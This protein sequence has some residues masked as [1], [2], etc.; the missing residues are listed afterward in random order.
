MLSME[1][2]ND[3]FMMTT[4]HCL[5]VHDRL[6]THNYICDFSMLG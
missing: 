4:R 3:F 1:N 5:G 6:L 2:C